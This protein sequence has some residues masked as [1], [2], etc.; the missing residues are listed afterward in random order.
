VVVSSIYNIGFHRRGFRQAPKDKTMTNEQ[1]FIYNTLVAVFLLAALSF[2]RLKR[3]KKQ[4]KK[5]NRLRKKQEK[6]RRNSHKTRVSESKKI[7]DELS[8]IKGDDKELLPQIIGSLR[9][10]NPYT[11]EELVLTAAEAQGPHI[12]AIRNQHYSNDGGKDGTLLVDNQEYLVQSKRYNQPINPKHIS[13]FA[14][15]IVNHE[16]TGGYF[17][18]VGR[19]GPKSYKILNEHPEIHL[20]SGVK[21]VGLMR[22]NPGVI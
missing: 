22:K 11:F 13:A 14:E 18:H 12:E 5:F 21:L 20:I 6:S 2:R 7:L 3:N 15:A 1:V 8:K 17:V 19:T 16:A 10:I 4:N 9:K